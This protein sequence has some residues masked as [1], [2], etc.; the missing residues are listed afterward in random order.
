MYLTSLG[1]AIITD[2]CLLFTENTPHT[3]H[4]T[5]HL[6]PQMNAPIG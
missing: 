5:P 2:Y 4:Q 3:R 1:N 6:L